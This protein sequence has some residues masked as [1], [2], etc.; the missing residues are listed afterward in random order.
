MATKERLFRATIADAASGNN[1]V[2]E[3]LAPFPMEATVDYQQIA[4]S[5]LIALINQGV[6][7][8]RDIEPIEIKEVIQ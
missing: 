7:K 6:I 4:L 3:F 5:N 2:I 1:F 8:I